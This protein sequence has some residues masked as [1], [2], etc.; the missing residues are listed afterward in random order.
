MTDQPVIIEGTQRL[1]KLDLGCGQ[2]PREGFEGVDL[3]APNATHKVDLFKLPFPWAD[4]SV[5]EI[6]CSHFLEHLPAREVGYDDLSSAYP[7]S[8]PVFA[9]APPPDAL[10]KDFLF[11][12]MDECYRVLAPG[13]VMTIIVPSATSDRGFQDP[14]HRRFFVQATFLYFAREWRRMN[15]LDH[16]RVE[17]D[18]AVNVNPI[19]PSELSVLHPEAQ[20]RRFNENRN[21]V[22]DWHAVLTKLPLSP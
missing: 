19:I 3:Y 12:F 17:C 2:N 4:G 16:Y 7:R 18:F 6:H 13:G 9:R 20:A 15:Q 1:L 8:C 22:L 11:A 5:A 21:T 14:T 10:G